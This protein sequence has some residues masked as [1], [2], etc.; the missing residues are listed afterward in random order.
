MQF[1]FLNNSLQSRLVRVLNLWQK[2]SVFPVEVIQPLLDLAADPNNAELVASGIVVVSY[3]QSLKKVIDK[4]ISQ[5][6]NPSCC[7]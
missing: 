3:D 7:E 5:V 1:F 6:Y 2:N 4:A